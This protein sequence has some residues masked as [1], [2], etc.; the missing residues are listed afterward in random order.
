MSEILSVGRC[1]V[2]RE[3][4]EMRIVVLGGEGDGFFDELEGSGVDAVKGD[5]GEDSASQKRG[6]AEG[7]EEGVGSGRC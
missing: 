4:A 1:E 6:V 5:G 3:E 2:G 7:A